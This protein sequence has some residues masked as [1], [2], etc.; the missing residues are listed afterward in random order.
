MRSFAVTCTN[1]STLALGNEKSAAVTGTNDARLRCTGIRHCGSRQAFRS[2][3]PAD[4][5]DCLMRVN[6]GRIECASSQRA[7]S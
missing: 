3:L 6:T 7:P 4:V 2:T 1:P 5:A